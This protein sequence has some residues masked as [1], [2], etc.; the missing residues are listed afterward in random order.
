MISSAKFSIRF[1]SSQFV[2][3]N[4]GLASIATTH[5]DNLFTLALLNSAVAEAAFGFLAPT[6]NFSNGDVGR[7]PVKCDSRQTET[8]RLSESCVDL[9]KLDWDSLETSWDFKRNPLL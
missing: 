7:M 4:A 9:S 6:M 5:E 8:D 2:F 1:M 3:T